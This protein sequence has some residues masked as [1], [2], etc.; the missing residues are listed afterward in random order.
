MGDILS[1]NA[2][3]YE[4]IEMTGPQDRPVGCQQAEL[5]HIESF[6]AASH[7]RSTKPLP[8]EAHA[9]IEPDGPKV[10]SDRLAAHPVERKRREREVEAEEGRALRRPGAAGARLGQIDAP[11]GPSLSGVE[12]GQVHQAD[13]VTV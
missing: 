5:D 8:P 4:P 10:V 12:A 9:L 13:A 11:I 7:L 6:V 3:R 2:G 1:E